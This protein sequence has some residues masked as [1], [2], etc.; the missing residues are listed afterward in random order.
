MSSQAIKSLQVVIWLYGL[1]R[2]D[3]LADSDMAPG[4][5]ADRCLRLLSTEELKELQNTKLPTGARSL[6]CGVSSSLRVY[7][8]HH[9]NIHPSMF[10]YAL[11]NLVEIQLCQMK[12]KERLAGQRE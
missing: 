9:Y 7:A 6:P 5:W 8:V 2:Q 11:I 1:W 12:E 4:E 3:W 10:D